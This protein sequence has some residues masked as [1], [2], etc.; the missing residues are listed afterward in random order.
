MDRFMKCVLAALLV[1]QGTSCVL[2]MFGVIDF[3]YVGAA[4]IASLT[5]AALYMLAD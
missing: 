4:V 3:V 1:M 5:V 2:A